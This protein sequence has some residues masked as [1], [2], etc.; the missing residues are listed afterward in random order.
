M[1]RTATSKMFRDTEVRQLRI[2]IKR[3]KGTSNFFF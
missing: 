1:I 3:F 2:A